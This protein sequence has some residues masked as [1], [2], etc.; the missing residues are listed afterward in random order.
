VSSYA[1][2]S[3]LIRNATDEDHCKHCCAHPGLVIISWVHTNPFTRHQSGVKPLDCLGCVEQYGP[4]PFC[5]RGNNLE[6]PR[7]DTK[8]PWG[9]NGVW[10]G[11][12]PNPADLPMTCDCN[13]VLLRQE[14]SKELLLALQAHVSAW[15]RNPVQ[16]APPMPVFDDPTPPL[17]PADEQAAL[18]ESLADERSSAPVTTTLL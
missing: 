1:P 15:D 18:A 3:G 14:D 10:R 6:F 2:G 16:P 17:H 7:G 13:A 5:E 11:G 4:C 9:K 12:K 8:P